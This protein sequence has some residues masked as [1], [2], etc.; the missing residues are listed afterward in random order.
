[1]L[2]GIPVLAQDLYGLRGAWTNDAARPFRLESLRGSYAVV[3]MAYGACKRVC[4]TSLR[5]MEQLQALADARQVQLTFVIVG[6]DPAQD[7]PADWAAYR[8][9][10]GLTRPNWH[11]VVGD[12]SATRRMAHWLGVNTWRY[13]DHVMHDLRIALVSPQ[14][15]IV[16]SLT[17][18]DQDLNDLLP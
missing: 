7:R 16:A 15:R 18:A 2:S 9:D 6:L 13:G 10:R 12:A 3:N 14:G 4:S 17:E 11:F 1:M 5:L 8:A